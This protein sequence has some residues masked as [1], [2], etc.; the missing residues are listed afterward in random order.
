MYPSRA[1][2]YAKW[3]KVRKETGYRCQYEADIAAFLAESGVTSK[4]EPWRI[5]YV[6]NISAVYK[7]DW[8]LPDQCI[9]IE[10]KGEFRK[11]DRDKMLRVKGQYPHLDIRIV[12]QQPTA[13]VA[14]KTTCAMWAE[15]NGFLW[16]KGPKL[17]TEWLT[18][19]PGARSR[20]A[21]AKVCENAAPP[22]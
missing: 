8:T 5:P 12:F 19:K 6:V 9:V 17:P 14:G 22:K 21:F 16:C 2:Q 7:P 20:K 10:A 18:H 1:A 11:E 15:N 3:N 4:Y 13:K